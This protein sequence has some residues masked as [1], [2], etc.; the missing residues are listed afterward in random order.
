MFRTIIPIIILTTTIAGFFLFVNPLYKEISILKKEISAYDEALNNS[1]KLES[2]RDKLIKKRNS[3]TLENVDRL[4]KLLPDGV[5]NIR[6][7]LEIEKIASPYGMVLKDVRYEALNKAKTD[8]ANAN[9]EASQQAI[10]TGSNKNYGSWDLEFSTE[11]SYDD[12]LSFLKDL[13]NNLRIVDVSSIKF[14]S[15]TGGNIKLA[16]DT[17]KYTFKIKTYWL[18]D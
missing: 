8:T 18:K 5:D 2:E 12:F 17:Y 11:G 10:N 16:N 7:I 6:L 4:N 3:L 13:E 15:T 14:S 1:K 9:T